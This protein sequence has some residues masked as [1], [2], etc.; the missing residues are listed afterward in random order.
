MLVKRI[1]SGAVTAALIAAGALVAATPASA[2]S[3]SHGQT[4]ASTL[5]SALVA[6]AG[7]YVTESNGV[8]TISGAA[9]TALTASEYAQVV[10]SI[11]RYNAEPTHAAAASGL[12][13]SPIV[14]KSATA[15]LAVAATAA[16]KGPTCYW[17]W[18]FSSHW[19]GYDFW[20]NKC[21]ADWI[22]ATT[23]VVAGVAGLTAA[24]QGF[25]DV[26]NDIAAIIAAAFATAGAVIYLQALTCQQLGY[27]GV[28]YH[29]RV[30]G[31]YYPAC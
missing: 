4:D 27:S 26:P 5:S 10:A 22:T 31:V 6:K 24:I 15:T 16:V 14:T 30:P 9:K 7:S 8:A 21:A 11:A 1:I 2:A 29:Y 20:M 3:T 17:A 19:Y 23:A 18:S 28:S 12:G 25:L 13:T